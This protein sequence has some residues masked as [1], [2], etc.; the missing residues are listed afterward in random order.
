MAPY[1]DIHTKK[2]IHHNSRW[3]GQIDISFDFRESACYN[4]LA[5]LHFYHAGTIQQE[6]VPAPIPAPLPHCQDS[7]GSSTP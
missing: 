3:S 5:M 7:R 4:S 6:P 2:I 1:S